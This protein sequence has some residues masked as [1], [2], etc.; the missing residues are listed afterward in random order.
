MYIYT[1]WTLPWQT[2]HRVWRGA[3]LP[4]KA[5]LQIVL[6]FISLD[7][8]EFESARSS[9]GRV[10][11][12]DYDDSGYNGRAAA[13]QFQENPMAE[14]IQQE[15][16]SDGIADSAAVIAIITIV[17]LAMYLWLSGMPT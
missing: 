15:R 5:Q 4:E 6:I 3:T 11:T 16:T 12:W 7:K 14:K 2:R 9:K 17:V 10:T 8:Y 13:A 1:S